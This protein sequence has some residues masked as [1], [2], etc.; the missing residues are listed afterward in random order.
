MSEL[1][2]IDIDSE[3]LKESLRSL[4]Y[5]AVDLSG[6]MRKIAQTLHTLTEDNFAAEGRPS[7]N[8]SQRAQDESGVTLQDTGRLAASVT[9]HHSASHAMIGSNV[10][11][12]AI[13]QFGGTIKR[14]ATSRRREAYEITM[15][16][17][18]YLP[19]TADGALQ[20]EAHDAVLDTILRHLTTAA[21]A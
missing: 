16:A 2:R 12:A 7:W 18:P 15:P 11:Y 13:H 5:A 8:P 6:A 9:T 1:V 17:R 3:R 19:I 4:Q 21:N 14:G 10:A 20:P